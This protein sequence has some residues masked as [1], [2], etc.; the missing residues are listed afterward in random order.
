MFVSTSFVPGFN[1]VAV[2]VSFGVADPRFCT[3]VSRFT[4]ERH[5]LDGGGGGGGVLEV[6]TRFEKVVLCEPRLVQ[7]WLWLVPQVLG[8]TGLRIDDEDGLERVL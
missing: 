4:R 7:V 2:G 5:E 1:P 8:R 3:S 6:D